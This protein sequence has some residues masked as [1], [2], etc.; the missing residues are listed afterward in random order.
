MIVVVFE[1]DVLT[2]ICGYASQRGRCLEEKQSFYDELKC[3][4][5]VLSSGDF[6]MCLDDINGH[7]G[8]HI[9][10]FNRIYGGREWCRSVEFGRMNVITFVRRGNYVC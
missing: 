10:G 7:I 8:R 9:E 1:E 4:W 6:V 3:E 5:D 2:L